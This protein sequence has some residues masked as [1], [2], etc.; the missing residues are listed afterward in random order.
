MPENFVRR[1]TPTAGRD[2][3][4]PPLTAS[5][6]LIANFPAR[7]PSQRVTKNCSELI[8]FWRRKQNSSPF[9]PLLQLLLAALKNTT[10]SAKQD[11]D[12]VVVK[13]QNFTS[14]ID[15]VPPTNRESE[16]GA[17]RAVVRVKTELPE[18]FARIFAERPEMPAAMNRVATLGALT[19]ENGQIFVGSR[20]S[21]YEDAENLL[22]LHVGLIVC[23]AIGAA[24]SLLGAM[25]RTLAGEGGEDEESVWS[26][27]DMGEVSE[28]LSSHCLCTTGGP[29][30]TAEFPLRDGAVSAAMGDHDTA[31]WELAADQPHPE[32]GGG[33]FCLLQMHH[34]VKDAKK[35]AQL[36]MQLNRLEWASEELTPHFGAWCHGRVGMNPAYASF[37]PNGLHSI[38]GIATN[39]SLWAWYRARWANAVLAS[40]GVPA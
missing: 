4:A 9:A 23:A 24:D 16:I 8:M 6:P 25:R 38:K 17:I 10:L 11:G 20:L 22:K 18:K 21:I 14:R 2:A 29:R 13:H 35:L 30:L 36:T 33:L 19:I 12:S 5:A 26:A 15:V 1:V 37:L 3:C 34:Q 31:L 32:M 27:D 7:S 28:Y 39:V 40:L